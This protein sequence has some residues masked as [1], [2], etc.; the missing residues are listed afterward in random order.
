MRHALGGI[1]FARFWIDELR[2]CLMDSI[3]VF[4]KLFPFQPARVFRRGPD[5]LRA[6]L[7]IADVVLDIPLRDLRVRCSWSPHRVRIDVRRANAAGLSPSTLRQ[8][9]AGKS[10]RDGEMDSYFHFAGV[11]G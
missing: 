5:L 8:E 1:D 7:P 9:H 2:P 3:P 6:P 11:K 10:H 4:P